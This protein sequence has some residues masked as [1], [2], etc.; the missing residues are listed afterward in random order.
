MDYG[1]L[2]NGEDAPGYTAP[3][4]L[5]PGDIELVCCGNF[6]WHAY[7]PGTGFVCCLQRVGSPVKLPKHDP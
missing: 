5:Q 2:D 6:E 7:A 4:P 3:L 1:E